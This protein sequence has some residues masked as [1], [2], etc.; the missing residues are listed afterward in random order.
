VAAF[1][2]RNIP[3]E[4]YERL[5]QRAG[6]E[7]RSINAEILSILERELTRPDLDEFMRRLDELR[8]RWTIPAGS[9]RPEGQI[10]ADRDSDHGRS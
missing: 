2:L 4:L 7:G 8:S 5:R 9:P 1:H 6:R 3:D 10:R